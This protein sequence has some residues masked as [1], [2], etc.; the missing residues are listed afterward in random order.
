MANPSFGTYAAKPVLD[1]ESK[2]L[3]R[4]SER[5][6]VEDAAIVWFARLAAHDATSLDRAGFESWL[7]DRPAHREAFGRVTR[8]WEQVGDVTA[9]RS[10]GLPSRPANRLRAGRLIPMAMAATVMMAI[11]GWLF[12]TSP[13][14]IGTG[15]GEQ[16]VVALGDGS[17]I[18]LNTRTRIELAHR[19]TQRDV[20]LLEG[21]AFFEVATDPLRPFTVKTPHGLITVLGTAFNVRVTPRDSVVSVAHGRVRAANDSDARLLEAGQA[22]SVGAVV[23]PL[24]F[25][26]ARLSGWRAGRL[27]YVDVPLADL[28][29]DLNRY[30]PVRMALAAGSAGTA[31]GQRRISASLRLE[32][33]ADML[34]ALTE[35]LPVRFRQVSA[36]LI[37]LQS[38][39]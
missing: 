28:I 13:T 10:P 26:P 4:L 17:R 32:D 35:I 16:R 38:S 11:V 15:I 21:E 36:D 25:D 31:L 18:E 19:A 20:T 33:Q 6:Q 29:E 30:V 1:N 9:A 12:M 34:R 39:G 8:L 2:E 37:I 7:A 24:A 14:S 5:R 23:A 27:D 3:Q 22:A